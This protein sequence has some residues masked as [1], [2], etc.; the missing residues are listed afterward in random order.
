MN[1]AALLIPPSLDAKQALRLRRFGLAALSYALAAALV[2][3]AWTFGELPASVVLEVAA[4]FLAFNLGLYLVIR[5]GFNL[6]FDD[7]SL[8]RFQILAAITVLMYIVYHMDDGRSVALF[9]CFFVF[10]FGIFRLNAREFTVVTLYALAAYALVI[11]LLMHLRPQ[12]IHDVP[13]EWMSWVMF[14]GWLPLF[15][16]IGGQINTLRRRLRESELRFRSLTEMS[17]DF[18]W[19]SDTGHRLTQRGSADKKLSAVSVFRQGAQVGQRRWEIP[20]LSP[21]EAGWQAH[22][23]LLD[24]HLPFR[25]FELSRVG[26]DGTERHISISGDPVF[27]KSGAFKGY[28][29]VGTDITARKLAE[30]ALKQEHARLLEAERDLLKAH[31]SLAEA[32]RLESVGRL[33]AGVAHEVKNPLTI[34]RFGIDHLSRQFSQERNQEV[35]DDVRGA[36]DRAEHVISDLLDFS[37]QK[38]FARRPTDIDQVID[39]AIHLVKHEIE[40]RN[41]AIVRNGS[42][43]LPPIYADPDR[44]VQVFINLLSNAA[45]SIAQDGRIDVVTRSLRLGE[46][47]L[48]RSEGSMFSIGEPVV[49]VDIRENG[50]GFSAAHEKKL[51]EPFFTTKPVG[52]GSGLGLAVSR[53]IVIMH[54]GSISI[55][56]R[57][58]GGVSALL[59]FRVAR[60]H[61]SD[62][63][64]NTGSR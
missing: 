36:I 18:Y 63:K 27:D 35:L 34:I 28:R 52:E 30:E 3:V 10:L 62:E 41:I 8:T 19:E 50:P 21:D 13:R 58:E 20:Y 6:R 39:K 56:N 38:T 55:S 57:A 53:N 11:V 59:M 45:Q 14:A 2:A 43:E 29:G 26:L 44:L 25:D 23:A 54:R 7:P 40:R 60:E 42:N 22:R 51:F 24:A 31:E 15:T 4:A 46:R 16:V 47:D 9:G 17:S 12:A 1:L 33:A 49:T 64:A 37:R 61:L 32:D 48:E 5:S